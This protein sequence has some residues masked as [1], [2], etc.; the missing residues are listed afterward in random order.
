MVGAGQLLAAEAGRDI[1]RQGGNAI[2]AAIATEMVL[3]LGEPQASRLGGGW[4]V[5]DTVDHPRETRLLREAAKVGA[6]TLGGLDMFVRQAA[7]QM[8]QWTGVQPDLVSARGWVA[9]EIAIRSGRSS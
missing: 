7:L 5:V 8:K 6:A 9:H 2:D 3:S 4:L 1:R